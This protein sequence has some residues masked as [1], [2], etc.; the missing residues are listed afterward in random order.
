MYNILPVLD[1]FVIA[2]S[3]NVP[4]PETPQFRTTFNRNVNFT[5]TFVVIVASNVDLPDPGTPV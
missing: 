5:T 2:I 4:V 1:Y 3:V